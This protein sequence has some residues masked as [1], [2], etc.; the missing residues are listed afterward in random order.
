MVKVNVQRQWND[1]RIGSVD[2]SKLENL[3]WDSVSGGVQAPSSQAFLMAYIWC[4]DIEGEIAHSG[5]PG[6]C[7][8]RIKVV[9]VK[10][11]NPDVYQQ[12]LRRVGPKPGK[13]KLK[14]L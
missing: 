3:E 1:W 11:D 4:T 14:T 6:Q 12:I 2:I 10:K 9:I 7:P 8:H 5:T 13:R